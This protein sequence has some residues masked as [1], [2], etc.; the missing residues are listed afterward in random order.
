MTK[1]LR[2]ENAKNSFDSSS[3][4]FSPL[5]PI[6][7]GLFLQ[8]RAPGSDLIVRLYA[9][10]TSSLRSCCTTRPTVP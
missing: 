4:G 3:R 5:S 1:Q 10:P 2:D 7:F 9:S 8:S 6:F